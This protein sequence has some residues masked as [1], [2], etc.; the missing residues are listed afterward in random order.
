VRFLFNEWQYNHHLGG[1]SIEELLSEGNSILATERAD[2]EEALPLFYHAVFWPP[3]PPYDE[4]VSI[5]AGYQDSIQLPPLQ[6]LSQHTSEYLDEL[7]RNLSAGEIEG[8]EASLDAKLS[9]I[10]LQ[11][12]VTVPR[13]RTYFRA[14]IGTSAQFV[15]VFD[16]NQTIFFKPFMDMEISAPPA[17]KALAGRVNKEGVSVLYLATDE[18]TALAEVRPHPGHRVS[19]GVFETCADLRV[20]DFGDLKITDF[21]SSDVRLDLFHLGISLD[22]ALSMP[23]TPEERHQFTVIQLV[24][25]L[26]QRQGYDAIQYRSSVGQGVNLCV[27]EPSK[28]QYQYDQSKVVHVSALRYDVEEVPTVYDPQDLMRISD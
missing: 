26:I 7:S 12:Q 8:M 1:D 3:Y 10:L 22:R 11:R 18:M 25:E 27:F 17:V 23:V 28:L 16:F 14:R 20:A 6:A 4:G 5:Y 9:E 24:A 19:V 21:S 15:D 2:S 13:G